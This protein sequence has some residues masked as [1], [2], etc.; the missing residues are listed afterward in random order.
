MAQ[1]QGAQRGMGTNPEI[2]RREPQSSACPLVPH[3]ETLLAREATLPSL[4]KV[5]AGVCGSDC[6]MRIQRASSSLAWILPSQ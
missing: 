2:P 4:C 5:P 1:W 3:S 6:V